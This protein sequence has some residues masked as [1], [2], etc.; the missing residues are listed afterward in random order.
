MYVFNIGDA[1][2]NI[3]RQTKPIFELFA[4]NMNYSK[5]NIR[6]I[7]DSGPLK[8]KIDE[9]YEIEIVSTKETDSNSQVEEQINQSDSMR[10]EL[11]EKGINEVKKNPLFGTGN[12]YFEYDLNNGYGVFKQTSHNLIIDGIINYGI[13]G[14]LALIIL[15]LKIVFSDIFKNM[16][17]SLYTEFFTIILVFL[18]NS[19]VQPLAFNPI[20]LPIFAISLLS[21]GDIN[22][23]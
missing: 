6:T 21:L 20:V 10:K 13:I 15:F 16:K 17:K 2:L 5:T 14:V 4:N 7:A 3:N 18:G 1:A 19:M 12:L 9:T 22:E 23:G 8:V 11:I